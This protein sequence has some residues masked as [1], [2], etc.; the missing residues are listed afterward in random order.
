MNIYEQNKQRDWPI[1]R[2][3]IANIS[4][5]FMQIGCF[6]LCLHA[7]WVCLREHGFVYM[8]IELIFLKLFAVYYLPI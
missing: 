2:H 4:Q 3:V 8:R 7:Y 6:G 1:E 5:Y